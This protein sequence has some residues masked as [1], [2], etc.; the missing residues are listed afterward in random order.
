MQR[1]EREIEEVLRALEND[2]APDNHNAE[3]ASSPGKKPVAKLFWAYEQPQEQRPAHA[4]A[5]RFVRGTCLLLVSALILLPFISA[6]SVGLIM[7]S[8]GLLLMLLRRGPLI[9]EAE[10]DLTSRDL[11]WTDVT[12]QARSGTS[13][14]PGMPHKR[15]DSRFWPK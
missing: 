11:R 6:V 7:L 12:V 10:R 14:A 15:Y 2:S 1:Y 4:S 3:T 5:D 13:G 9:H 8:L